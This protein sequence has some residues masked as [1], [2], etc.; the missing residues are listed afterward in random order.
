VLE[1]TYNNANPTDTLKEVVEFFTVESERKGQN[2]KLE[3]SRPL[4]VIW[5]D[6][7]RLRQVVL[8]LLE[9]A[10]KYTPLGGEIIVRCKERKGIFGSRN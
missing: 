9:N 6:H 2:L 10:I 5:A 7:G 1:L 3:I 8:N 4:P